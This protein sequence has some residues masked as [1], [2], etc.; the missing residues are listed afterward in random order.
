MAKNAAIAL[1]LGLGA[2]TVTT[3]LIARSKTPPE[4]LPHTYIPTTNDIMACATMAEL[5]VYYIYIGQLR[6]LNQIDA[7]TYTK[8]YNAYVARFYELTGWQQ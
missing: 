4:E 5:E 6:T 3:L 2:A 8:L 7:A 1:G